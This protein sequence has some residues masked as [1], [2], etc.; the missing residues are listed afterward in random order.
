MRNLIFLN[1]ATPEENPFTA[2]LAAKLT[3]AGYEVWCDFHRL[4]GGQ[5]FWKEIEDTIRHK[6]ARFVAIT[7]RI[8]QSK[9]GVQ[10]ELALA[11][12]V[13]K[14]IP[15]FVIPVR[16]DDLDFTQLKI[17]VLQKNVIDFYGNWQKGLTDL[18]KTLSDAGIKTSDPD[19]AKVLPWMVPEEQLKVVLRRQKEILET[20]WLSIESIPQ[21]IST[22]QL[23]G[24]VVPVLQTKEN[25]RLPWF[26][27]QHLLCGFA[28]S[29]ELRENFGNNPVTTMG[30]QVLLS[31]LF[32]GE[33]KTFGKATPDDVKKM[34]VNLVRQAWDLKMSSLGLLPFSLANNVVVWFVPHELLLGNKASFVDVTGKTRRKNLVGRSERRKVYWHYGVS[35]HPNIGKP[36]RV[37]L[38]S[39]VIFTQDGRTPLLSA[40]RMHKLRRGFCRSWWNDHF[41]SLLRAFLQFISA[42]TQTIELPAG[43][44]SKIVLSSSTF[45][46]ESEVGLSDA[47]DLPEELT[48]I[49]DDS[50]DVDEDDDQEKD[51]DDP[52]EEIAE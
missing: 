19:I 44:T 15:N 23:A 5:D 2:W 10:N 50:V 3:L 16:V 45:T 6:T 38:S 51:R 47:F 18:L 7:S 11:L 27:H 37:E 13:E 22:I 21:A 28:S 24:R 14:Q 20:N 12:I 42:G 1:H 41:R 48:S 29:S 35:A 36:W 8:S 40:D 52:S 46:V 49:L 26:Q 32:E 9:T 30:G 25:S 33:S 39:H 34:L 4:R 31:T 17:T 43:T